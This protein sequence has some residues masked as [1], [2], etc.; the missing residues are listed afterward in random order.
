MLDRGFDYVFAL[1][2]LGGVVSDIWSELES[3]VF[4]GD[5]LVNVGNSVEFVFNEVFVILIQDAKKGKKVC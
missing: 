4:C 2:L 5:F 1:W 3:D